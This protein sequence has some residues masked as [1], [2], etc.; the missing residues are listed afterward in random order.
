[1]EY[2]IEVDSEMEDILSRNA[3]AAKM[4]VNN[5]IAEL[6]KRYVIDAHIMEKSEAWQNGINE[7]AEIELD[8][9]NL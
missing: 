9:A 8:W 4:S 1:M 6:L 3:A 2:K 7:C 5:Y